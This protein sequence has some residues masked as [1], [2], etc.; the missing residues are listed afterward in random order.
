MADGRPKGSAATAAREGGLPGGG[1][2]SLRGYP[3]Y[4][5][6]VV[7]NTN[8]SAWEVAPYYRLAE[9]RS[10]PVRI[11]TVWTPFEVC[12]LR[13]QHGVPAKQLLAMYQRLLSEEL[14]PWWRHEVIR[15]SN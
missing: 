13:Q 3:D 6:V 10:V 1:N 14:P 12:L 5:V 15:G 9:S 11:V 8:I 4:D 2:P 7:D